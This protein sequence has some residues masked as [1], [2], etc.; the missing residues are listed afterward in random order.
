MNSG[1]WAAIGAVVAGVIAAVALYF[2]IRSTRASERAAS[3]ADRA[4][5]AAE[6]QAE[7][8]RKIQV[9]TSQPYIWLDVREDDSQGVLLDL[10]I[11]N[12]GPTVA[13]NVRVRI[14]PPFPVQPQIEESAIAQQQLAD[15]I[16]SLAPGAMI[17]WHLGV[18][19]NLIRSQGQQPHEISITADGPFGPIDELTYVIDLANLRGQPVRPQGNLHL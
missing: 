12:S 14:D 11:G 9:A 7:I 19:H 3:S 10:V 6:D 2:S 15:G 17:R 13:T 4:A 16:R 8:Q 1:D 5:K 18:G